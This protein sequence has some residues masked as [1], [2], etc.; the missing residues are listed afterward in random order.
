MLADCKETYVH[1][2]EMYTCKEKGTTSEYRGPKETVKRLI[3]PIKNTYRNVT[4][5]RCYTSFDL[6]KDLYSDYNLTLVGTM[7]NNRKHILEEMKSVK[8]R[9]LYSSIF[10]FTDPSSGKPPQ[11]GLD[12]IKSQIQQRAEV[13]TGLQN[14]ILAKLSLEGNLGKEVRL[15]TIRLEK[16]DHICYDEAHTK[17]EQKN[18][19]PKTTIVC[20][21]LFVCGRHSKKNKMCYSCVRND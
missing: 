17:R 21:V 8:E 1:S 7:Q 11:S 18:K 3:A 5:N 14:N 19:L 4:T 10:A 16:E 6:A 12:L 9:E 15:Q 2:K 20:G 13:I